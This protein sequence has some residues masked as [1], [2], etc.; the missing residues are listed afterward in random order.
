MISA[1]VLRASVACAT[2]LGISDPICSGI[3]DPVVMGAMVVAVFAFYWNAASEPVQPTPPL[4]RNMVEYRL[5]AIPVEDIV[6]QCGEKPST[7]KKSVV[8]V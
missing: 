4:H 6:T 3:S 1:S 2:S 7:S 8:V 5:E